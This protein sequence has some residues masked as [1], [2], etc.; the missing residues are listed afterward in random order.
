MT[1]TA[2]PRPHAAVIAA[3]L[4]CLDTTP[5]AAQ[6]GPGTVPPSAAAAQRSG[7]IYSRDGDG[8]ILIRATRLTQPMELDGRLAEEVYAQIEPITEFIQSTP[9]EGLPTTERTEAWV[10]F[11]DENVYV[12]CRCWMSELDRIVAN[13]MRRDSGNLSNHDHFAVH[14]D[15][16]NDRRNGFQF[17]V[18][19]AGGMRDGI[20]TDERYSV[21][22]NGVWDGRAGR[23]EGGWISELAIP[24]KTLRYGPGRQ[25]IWRIQFRRF[26]AAKSE[27]TFLTK[28]PGNFSRS[29]LNRSSFAAVL[30]GLEVP[31]AS[32]NL[33][34]KPYAI[35]R[36]TTDRVTVP[37]TR[38]D[39]GADPG[40]DVK[41]G[42]TEGL[43]A[44]FT[45]NTDFAQVEADENQVN[46]TRFS[47]SFP[48]K[49]EFFLENAGL[50]AFGTG[51][52]GDIGGSAVPNIFYSRRIGLSGST[53]VPLIG[54]G[55]V[56]GRVGSWSVGA[57]NMT[58][59][60]W[61][62]PV[63]TSGANF[64][65]LRLRRDILRRSTIGGIY[66]RKSASGSPENALWGL[67]ANFAFYQ[68]LYFSGY[69]A[70]NC[71]CVDGQD[72]VSYRAQFNYNADR[73][74]LA[75][76]RVV[77]EPDFNVNSGIGFMRRR[78]F[79]RN[80]AQARFSPRTTN[81]PTIRQYT[82]EVSLDY[83][84]DNDN[85]LESR[86]LNG[87]FDMELHS[88]DRF[89]VRYDGQ[90]ELLVRP[91]EVATDVIIPPGS[92]GFDNVEVSYSLGAQHRVSGTTSV[93][94]GS[95]YEGDKTGASFRGRVEITPQLSVEP[96]ANI[97]WV[98]LPYGEFTDKVVG[99]R[100]IFTMT[101]R[102]FAA[103]LI[104]YSSSSTSLSTNLRFRWEYEP[105]S[106][107]FIVY[108]EG[109]STLPPNGTDLENRGFVI[110]FNRL[111]RF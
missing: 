61:Q 14:L 29:G 1:E 75:F 86:N 60:D 47:I 100:T 64:T 36:L 108:T 101:P 26:I 5:G 62:H 96:T 41:Y 11:D 88:T 65:V 85:R 53:A 70:K 35:S 90:Y 17:Y 89:A 6:P 49:R 42:L 3:M 38:N 107:L 56:A 50:F 18:T 2:T 98:D 43:T 82:Y 12:T 20:V 19:A 67:D 103:A 109:R 54:G 10:F 95:F 84:T 92:Y 63:E 94:Y 99:A 68:N 81:H 55:R 91:F 32:A 45:F 22:W 27:M 72:D 69:F 51:G 15:T 33:E 57:L 71:G 7:P 44:D 83:I 79:R 110:K 46:L 8:Q 34:L 111:F 76:D 4:L 9:V 73:Y 80:F 106:E 37:A 24:F 97:S 40:I 16:F 39:L 102:M 31:P 23:F 105:G 48:E 52:G 93:E 21:D 66:T 104:Q 77:A 58:E 25:Q 59:G 28:M 13:D 87:T 30:E 74:G 78:N